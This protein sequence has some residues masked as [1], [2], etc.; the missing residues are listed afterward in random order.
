M[1]YGQ[2]SLLQFP[3]LGARNDKIDFQHS[4]RFTRHSVR[5]VIRSQILRTASIAHFRFEITCDIAIPT[6]PNGANHTPAFAEAAATQEAHD[7]M[8]IIT[9]GLALLGFRV[10]SDP[11]FLSEVRT[12]STCCKLIWIQLTRILS[13]CHEGEGGI[14]GFKPGMRTCR[15]IFIRYVV[16]SR[17]CTMDE[18]VTNRLALEQ[19]VDCLYRRRT[20]SRTKHLICC[21]RFH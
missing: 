17:Y 12:S 8:L 18:T 2:L 6:S 13:T 10:L 14:P 4:H 15:F 19:S 1:S 7:A 21:P 16:Y 11:L 5:S 3:V 9:K 20:N